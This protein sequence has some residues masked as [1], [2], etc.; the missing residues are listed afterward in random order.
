MKENIIIGMLMCVFFLLGGLIASE[1][2][3][4]RILN[5]IAYSLWIY[6]EVLELEMKCLD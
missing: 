2:N 4:T 3:S 1:I 5:D 6:D